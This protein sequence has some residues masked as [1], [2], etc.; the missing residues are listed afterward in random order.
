M[1]LKLLVM[2]KLYF[3]LLFICISLLS[4]GQIVN[5]P[6]ANFKN[7][8]VNSSCASEIPFGTPNDVDTNNNDEIE[9]SEASAIV[10][11]EVNGKSIASLEGIAA[12][13]NLGYLRCSSNLLT[14]LD[15]TNLPL[16][17]LESIG[18]LNTSIISGYMPTLVT[19]NCSYSSLTT[20]D[21]SQFPNLEYLDCRNTPLTSINLSGMQSLTE[22]YAQYTLLTSIDCSQTAVFRLYCNDSPNLTSINVR[23]NVQSENWCEECLIN[24]DFSNL[25]N[26]ST[27]CVDNGE[28]SVLYF[29]PQTTQVF[30]G[31]NCDVLLSVTS[32]TVEEA[33]VLYPNPV[34]DF[35]TI[36]K[37]NET[38]IQSVSIYNPL[39]QLVKTLAASEL[40]A[41]SS[42]DVSALE[43]G[44][45][46]MEISSNNG[47]TTKK[48]VKL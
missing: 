33:M 28:E 36:K 26:L 27:V 5:I 46:F 41:S 9:V 34:A 30:G 35:I 8:L 48:F 1:E 47:K 32:K 11:L 23:N 24:F 14:T 29:I 10:Y 44:T 17:G 37:N 40:E 18:N 39:G 4:F 15:I 25:P 20:L 43:T 19:L 3:S 31:A 22:L 45:Y 38:E 2:K 6:D 16:G 13:S 12:F 42:I 21:A 7:A